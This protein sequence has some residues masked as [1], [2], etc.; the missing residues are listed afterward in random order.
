MLAVALAP[1]CVLV[2][3]GRRTPLIRLHELKLR[4]FTDHAAILV[5]SRELM[6]T[7]PAG[8][9]IDKH[10]SDP[11]IPEP[12]RGAGGWLSISQD[13]VWI[14][15]GNG[16]YPYRLRA[17]GPAVPEEVTLRPYDGRCYWDKLIDGVWMYHE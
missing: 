5:A 8:G 14:E 4:Y 10:C 1:I 11:R 9:S 12:L 13:E 17:F 16:F 15:Y 7:A 3:V 2:P 6:K